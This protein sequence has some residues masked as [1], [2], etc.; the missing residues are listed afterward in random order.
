MADRVL[1]G[2]HPRL[3]QLVALGLL[4]LAAGVILAVVDGRRWGL[5]VGFLGVL[6]LVFGGA[7]YVAIGV[8]ERHPDR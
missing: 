5:R 4:L 2:A 1:G 6:L 3:F 7:G 8:F